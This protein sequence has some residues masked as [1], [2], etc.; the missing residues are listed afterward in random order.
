MSAR[1][2]THHRAAQIAG[3]PRLFAKIQELGKLNAT[4]AAADDAD[5]KKAREE[6]QGVRDDAEA[7]KTPKGEWEA[8]QATI[9][10]GVSHQIAN[11]LDA[12]RKVY[13]AGMKKFPKYAS[14]F[15]GALDRLDATAAKPAGISLRTT[16]VQ[17][18]ELLLAIVLLQPPATP[19]PEA[20]VFFWKAVKLA[21]TGKYAE[22]G[23]Q[24]ALAKAAHVKQA[25][26]SP[27]GGLN[28]LSDPLHEIFP[29]C[30]DDLKTYWDL[31]GAIYSNKAVAELVKKDGPSKA[32]TELAR[33][34]DTAVKLMAD[35]QTANSSLVKAQNDYK[36]AS[37]KLKKAES[38]FQDASTRLTKSEKDLK[39]TKEAAIKFEKEYRSAEAARDRRPR[40][41]WLARSKARIAADS[42][43]KKGDDLIAATGQGTPGGETP[44][45]EVRCR[46]DTRRAEDGCAA[47]HGPDAHRASSHRHDGNRRR[48][49]GGGPVEPTSPSGSPGPRRRP[50]SPPRNSRPKPNG[51]RM[52]TRPM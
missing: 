37:T 13:E 10:L 22:A 24:I 51:S 11:E 7:V 31:R 36:E 12:A 23:E 29:R 43:R 34:A 17:A 19:E 45:R 47:C 2:A 14:T 5:L 44:A 9:Y 32:L 4:V 41:S 16:P 38:D 27:G 8:V 30:C 50:G 25:K 1:R 18:E 39:D 3:Q 28:P 49:L 6:L 21:N 26:V 33:R 35:L 40:R 20:G 42:R 48:R 46:H 15:Q 52:P